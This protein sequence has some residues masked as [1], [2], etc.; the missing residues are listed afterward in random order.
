MKSARRVPSEGTARSGK[1][2]GRCE[3][4]GRPANQQSRAAN[5]MPPERP[6]VA[7]SPYPGTVTTLST[8]SLAKWNPWARGSKPVLG[9]GPPLVQMHRT[10][11]A[12]LTLGIGQDNSPK[13]L[14]LPI[15]ADQP[16]RTV[17]TAAA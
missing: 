17:L 8:K 5:A 3:G 11:A 1:S 13:A 10:N 16:L 9:T 2:S 14:L 15:L 6:S 4:T 12:I 7:T